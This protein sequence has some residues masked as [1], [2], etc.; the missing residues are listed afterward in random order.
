MEGEDV[1]AEADDHNHDHG[2][3]VDF[4]VCTSAF[5][6]CPTG[7]SVHAHAAPGDLDIIMFTTTNQGTFQVTDPL[8]QNLIGQV[9][10]F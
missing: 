6:I 3:L 8:H 9:I 7:L 5:G 10:V 2:E 4:H 1:A